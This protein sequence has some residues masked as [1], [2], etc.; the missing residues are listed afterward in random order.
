MFLR[1]QARQWTVFPSN[2]EV[3][4]SL[5]ILEIILKRLWDS[6][7][8]FK[9]TFIL[10][11]NSTKSNLLAY[12]SVIKITDSNHPNIKMMSFQIFC[13]VCQLIVLMILLFCRFYILLSRFSNTFQLSITSSYLDRRLLQICKKGSSAWLQ[14]VGVSKIWYSDSVS[15]AFKLITFLGWQLKMSLSITSYRLLSIILNLVNGLFCNDMAFQ[16]I[17]SLRNI[18][19][20][21]ITKMK[22]CLPDFSNHVEIRFDWNICCRSLFNW[23]HGFFVLWQKLICYFFLMHQRYVWPII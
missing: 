14:T 3:T 6:I 19:N 22:M 23:L 17:S 15:W 13:L 8:F 7:I 5:V 18:T 1:S 16:I 4:R 12:W 10:F 11:S 20:R 21:S 2:F 9:V